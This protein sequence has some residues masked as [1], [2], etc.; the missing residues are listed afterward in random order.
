M[1]NVSSGRKIRNLF[2]IQREQFKVFL[3]TVKVFLKEKNHLNKDIGDE[4]LRTSKKK[5]NVSSCLP[6]GE[7]K[8]R[9]FL[10]WLPREKIKRI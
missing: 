1:K 9:I 7:R 5:K 4:L 10:N 2:K 6:T 8:I 3:W